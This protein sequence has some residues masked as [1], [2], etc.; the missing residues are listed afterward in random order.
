MYNI[1]IHNRLKI[2]SGEEWLCTF[3][4]HFLPTKLY[5]V[6]PG[7]TCVGELCGM[8]HWTSVVRTHTK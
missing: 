4:V 7:V 3:A 6:F 8:L 1:F 5:I 2:T